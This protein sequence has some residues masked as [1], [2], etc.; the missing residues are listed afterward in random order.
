M[1]GEEENYSQ[2]NNFTIRT[3]NS[4]PRTWIDIFMAIIPIQKR[5]KWVSFNSLPKTQQRHPCNPRS[6]HYISHYS[7]NYCTDSLNK[8]GKKKF[9][10]LRCL[11]TNR[12]LG[13]E[14]ETKVLSTPPPLLA[15]GAW[16]DSISVVV[17]PFS[18][19]EKSYVQTRQLSALR[20]NFNE[21]LNCKKPT[22]QISVSHGL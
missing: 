11:D 7:E 2:Y 3:L 5:T 9:I 12:N 18:R 14:E 16:K 17:H 22:N 4:E 19:T 21:I 10:Y 1:Q 8:E 13:Y 20:S 15:F 6:L